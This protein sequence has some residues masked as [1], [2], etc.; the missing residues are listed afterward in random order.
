M[1]CN[2]SGQAVQLSKQLQSGEHRVG[3]DF[4]WVAV[5]GPR[6]IIEWGCWPPGRFALNSMSNWVYLS[7][8]L[9]LVVDLDIPRGNSLRAPANPVLTFPADKELSLF[10]DL[11]PLPAT[12]GDTQ[13][14]PSAAGRS[15]MTRPKSL[16]SMASP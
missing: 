3:A 11:G 1:I 6:R 16:L 15:R 14:K 9:W 4:L 7:M 8:A 13:T 12:D 10:P 5:H 2:G